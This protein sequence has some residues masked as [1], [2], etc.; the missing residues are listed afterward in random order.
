MKREGQS[1]DQKLP[2]KP[3]TKKTS[4]G[5][6]WVKVKVVEYVV[7][8][9]ANSCLVEEFLVSCKEAL[10]T[11]KAQRTVAGLATELTKESCNCN[12]L[13]RKKFKKRDCNFT[14]WISP[15]RKFVK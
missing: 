14:K 11:K 7:L 6:V 5:N 15:L 12:L 2:D 1:M 4:W 3:T 9:P 13:E 8:D 10:R